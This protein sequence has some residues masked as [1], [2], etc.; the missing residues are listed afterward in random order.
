MNGRPG[1]TRPGPARAVTA[2]ADYLRLGR[3]SNLPTVWTNVLAGAVLA[4]GGVG[5]GRLALLMLALSLFYTGG[6]YLNDAF[7]REVDARERPERPIPSGRIAAG[8]VFAIGFGMLAAGLLL[9]APG[10]AAA[11]GAGALLA[12][13][14]TY[15]DAHHKA[16]RLS[17]L[18]MGLCRVLVYVTAALAVAGRVS[19]AV[20]GGA[21]ALLAYLIGLTYVAR[22]ENLTEVRNVWPLL[23]LAAPFLYAVP[24]AAGGGAA[25]VV[26]AGFLAWVVHAV[27]L[28]RRA[29]PD[30]RRAVVSL[31]AGISLLDALLIAG[32]GQTAAAAAALVGF[33][34]TLA[35]QRWVPGT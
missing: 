20:V 8:R 12:G 23:F 9:L 21:A 13:A 27:S 31:I 15:Y 14:I 11:V 35:L 1:A 22:Q 28:L 17:P 26:Y 30:I 3:V 25:A 4:G 10:G 33:A 2:A 32:A 5:P 6:M 7:D 29:R 18:I 16:N 34:L 24:A 19:A